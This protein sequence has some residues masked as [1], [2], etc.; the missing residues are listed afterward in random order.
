MND[1]ILVG[2]LLAGREYV[3]PL[4]TVAREGPGTTVKNIALRVDRQIDPS[5]SD[6]WVLRFGV[7]LRS[8]QFTSR[9]ETDRGPAGI[10]TAGLNLVSPSPAIRL[11]PGEVFALQARTRGFP[12]SLEGLV[13][14][15]EYTDLRGVLQDA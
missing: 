11:A 2:D 15:P 12:S 1:A 4:G 8:G 10:S 7:L 9:F 5:P 14:V 13:V 3:R 6:A